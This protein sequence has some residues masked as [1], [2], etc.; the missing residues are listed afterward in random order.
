MR[1]E[2]AFKPIQ[3]EQAISNRY[4]DKLTDKCFGAFSYTEEAQNE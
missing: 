2:E 1:I 4:S 3:S